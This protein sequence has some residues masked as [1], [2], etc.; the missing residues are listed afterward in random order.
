M[1]EHGFPLAVDVCALGQ[2]TCAL[3]STL[4]SRHRGVK[5]V[6]GVEGS[7]TLALTPTKLGGLNIVISSHAIMYSYVLAL[8]RESYDIAL[9]ITTPSYVQCTHNMTLSLA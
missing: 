3:T 8:T 2:K 7:L 4:Y 5:V 9:C 6:G 1:T